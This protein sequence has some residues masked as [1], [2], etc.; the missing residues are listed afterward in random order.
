MIR[1]FVRAMALLLV[2]LI[3]SVAQAAPPLF[4]VQTGAATLYLFGTFHA[5]PPKTED[6]LTPTLRGALAKSDTVLFEIDPATMTGPAAQAVA[7]QRGLVFDDKTLDTR[8][9][10]DVYAQV[11]AAAAKHGLPASGMRQLQPWLAALTLTQLQVKSQGFDLQNGAELQL[12][13]L[14]QRDK[15]RVA[16]LETIEKQIGFFA[17]LPLDQQ[18]DMV[19]ESLDEADESSKL[20]GQMINAWTTGDESALDTLLTDKLKDYPNLYDVLMRQRNRAWLGQLTTL[21]QKR[22]TSLVAVG[23]AHLIGDDSVVALLR[24]SGYRVERINH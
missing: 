6:W 24:Q 14:I 15:A 16:G 4:K 17:D 13:R 1:S 11:V 23:T 20:L 9:P 7:L 5:L 22:G 10:P 19:K 21:L 12:Y 18:V 8:L 2:L 3:P